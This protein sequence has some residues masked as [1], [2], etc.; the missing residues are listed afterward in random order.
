MYELIYTSTPQGLIAG[1]SGFSTVAL[2]E[3]FPP[4]LISP[5]ENLSGYKTLFPPEDERAG[6][7]P[8][9][10]SCQHYYFGRTLYIVLSRIAFAGLSYTG[11]SNVLAHHLLFTP[12]ELQSIPG[13]SA[14]ILRAEENFTPWSG[15][16]GMLPQKSLKKIVTAPLLEDGANWAE[17]AG[18][19][20]FSPYTADLFNRNVPILLSFDPLK[21]SGKRILD[22]IAETSSHLT[23]EELLQFTF[24][25]YSYSSAIA[26]PLAFRAYPE[27]SVLLESARR[28]SSDSVINLGMPN[29]VPA[30]WRP[31]GTEPVEE[32]LPEEMWD[33]EPAVAAIEIL[34]PEAAE[35]R[36]VPQQTYAPEKEL[37]QVSAEKKRFLPVIIAVLIIAAAAAVVW[38]IASFNGAKERESEDNLIVQEES[39]A[40]RPEKTLPESRN[41]PQ[42]TLPAK[43]VMPTKKRKAAALP[44]APVVKA[45]AGAQTDGELLSRQEV[46]QL[47]LSLF[48]GKSF[49]LPAGLRKADRLTLTM[50]DPG[51]AGSA[52]WQSAVKGNGSA[53]VTVYPLKEKKGDFSTTLAADFSSANVMKLSLDKGYFSITLPQAA[54]LSPCMENVSAVV[55]SGNGRRLFRADLRKFPPYFKDILSGNPGKLTVKKQGG[56]YSVNCILSEG[57]WLFRRRFDLTVNGKAQGGSTFRSRELPVKILD[58]SG[59]LTDILTRNQALT[60]LRMAE[61]S[62]QDFLRKNADLLIQTAEGADQTFSQSR[63]AQKQKLEER[64]ENAGHFYE[65]QNRILAEKLNA[66]SPVLFRKLAEDMESNQTIDIRRMDNL[67]A[68]DLAADI[69][70]GVIERQKDESN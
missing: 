64:R 62:Y 59:I 24:T 51:G 26:N 63:M 1:R 25:T 11:R 30:G 32:L 2:T 31:P 13:G 50:G 54:K 65:Q 33:T 14:A 69:S 19:C 46:F 58:F 44:A 35:I 39:K 22:L 23:Q 61:K 49:M 45:P 28:L 20:Y 48:R 42:K 56:V 36:P 5:I 3:G 12:E 10:Y 68:A 70:I 60:K 21:I 16:P 34:E 52:D 66:A 57:M 7:N 6:S 38:H 29:T 37:P 18:D 15:T 47:Y 43:P 55:F 9:N 40:V 17:L 53:A 4:N 67:S 41:V 8:V 27:G